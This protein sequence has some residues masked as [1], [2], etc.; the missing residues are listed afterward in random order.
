MLNEEALSVLFLALVIG[1]FWLD[2]L[3]AR[4]MAI[5]IAKRACKARGLQLLDQTVALQRIRPRWTG[6]GVRF[7]RIYRFEISSAGVDRYVARLALLGIDLQWID[8]AQ[9]QSTP[10]ATRGT[11]PRSPEVF[12]V[13]PSDRD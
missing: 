11:P 1:W 2:A 3:R 7:L 4:E 9:P 8:L 6:T 10:E 5:G 12:D 13:R